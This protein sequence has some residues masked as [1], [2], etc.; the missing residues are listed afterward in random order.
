VKDSNTIP[1][2]IRYWLH[3]KH[4]QTRMYK[5]ECVMLQ[6]IILQPCIITTT[7]SSLSHIISVTCQVYV[8]SCR[9][10]DPACASCPKA[11]SSTNPTCV[12]YV[13][14]FH[15]TFLA[16]DSIYA[17]AHYRPMPSSVRPSVRPSV[18]HT[19]DQSKTAEVRIM[20]P[21]PQSSPMTLVSWRL[22]S[23]CNSK[24]KIGSGGVE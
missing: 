16:R 23:P 21:L 3:P 20:Q 12:W 11:F 8:S 14:S 7:V 1:I 4:S 17:I 22:T 10:V 13:Q 18:H 9:A 19:V 15:F 5:V 24:G 2:K 6:P